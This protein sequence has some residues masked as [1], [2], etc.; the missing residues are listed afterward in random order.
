MTNSNTQQREIWARLLVGKGEGEA[1][2]LCA[3]PS[4]EETHKAEAHL[5]A[6]EGFWFDRYRAEELTHDDPYRLMSYPK[7]EARSVDELKARMAEL[8]PG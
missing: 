5:E 4:I 2:V 8:F 6:S 7:Y 3:P 1:T